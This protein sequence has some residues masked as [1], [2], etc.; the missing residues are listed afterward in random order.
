MSETRMESGQRLR[1][2][3]SAWAASMIG[4]RQPH[5]FAAR[6]FHLLDLLDGL[7]HVARVRL[8]HRL[9]DDGGVA[10]DR[11]APDLHG[12]RLA[13]RRENIPCR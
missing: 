6:R 3:A 12:P 11:E 10:A 4:H 9:H 7:R 1:I 2:S 13:P 5:D 8:G